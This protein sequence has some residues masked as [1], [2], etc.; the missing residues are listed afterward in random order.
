MRHKRIFHLHGGRQRHFLRTPPNSDRRTNY[1]YLPSSLLCF[2][3]PQQS[4]FQH[5][6]AGN[7]TFKA[8]FSYR[9]QSMS[10]RNQPQL[11]IEVSIPLRDSSIHRLCR[12][13][14]QAMSCLPLTWCW[15]PPLCDRV[16]VGTYRTMFLLKIGHLAHWALHTLHSAKLC[17]HL[18]ARWLVRWTCFARIIWS[19]GWRCWYTS[20][21]ILWKLSAANWRVEHRSTEGS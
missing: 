6:Q 3:E 16:T 15:L 4:G 7:S 19:R 2:L 11:H 9:I 13:R 12:S 14:S 5:L 10:S 20:S 1:Q 21:E 8:R 18:D 17:R